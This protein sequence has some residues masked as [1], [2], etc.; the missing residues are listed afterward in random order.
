MT[1][2]KRRSHFLRWRTVVW[3][4]VLAS[5]VVAAPSQAQDV[6]LPEEI[7]GFAPGE[8]YRL[9]DYEQ[10][11][12][13]YEAVAQASNRVE[14]E[15]IG[16]THQ[17][18]DLLL[19]HIS[20]PEN[21]QNLEHYR[22]I[23]QRLALARD[24]DD[25]AARDLASEGK[26]VIWI[27]HGLH[28]AERAHSQAGPHL[29]YHLATDESPETARILD[30]VIL[31]MMPL[32]N[33][34]GHTVVVDWYREQRGTPFEETDAP[35]VWHEYIDHDNNRDWY[36]LLQ[37]ESRAVAEV[38]YNTWHPQIVLNHH[39]MG[40]SP[41]RMFIPPFDEPVNPHIPA[42]AVRGTNLVG[43]HMA[44]RFVAEGKAGIQQRSGFDMWWNGGMR[45]AP[46]FH[47]M[48]GILTESTHRS[49]VPRYWE[50]DEI[51]GT[52]IIGGQEQP[53]DEPSVFYPD[54]WM[55]GWSTLMQMV[56]YHHTASMA[57]LDI[58]SLRREAWL[59]NKY[60]MGRDA[61]A[62]GEEGSPFA[63]VVP[64]D[65]WDGPEALEMLRV[66]D[67]GGI[68]IHRATADFTADGAAYEAGSFVLYAGQAYRAHLRDLMEPQNYPERTQ[69]PGGP[70]DPPYDMAGWTLPIQMGVR[71]DIIE[72][73][74]AVGVERLEEVPT[75]PGRVVDAGS[76]HYLLNPRSNFA[77]RA[78]NRLLSEGH[79][80]LRTGESFTR[81]GVS[82][83]EGTFVI[84]SHGE[85]TTGLL[86]ELSSQLGL[87][88]HGVDAQPGVES[89]RLSQPRV[90]KYRS[91]V[92]SIDGGWT[93]WVFDQYGFDYD[94][95][96]DGD[97]R[98]G[99]LAGYDVLIMPAAP[100]RNLLRGHEEGT[101]PEAYVGGLGTEGA[102]RIKE[103]VQAGGTVVAWDG[104]TDFL[105][106]QL[107]L[108]VRN[109]VATAGRDTFFIPGSLL[110]LE[111]GTDHPVAYG[112]QETTGAWFV[113]RRGSQSRS[114]EIVRPA[115]VDD[116]YAGERRR[117]DPPRVE[118][119]ARFAED[120]LLASGWAR[121]E[122]RF[123][124]GQPAVLRVG[125]G[126]GDLV[127]IGVRPQ[128]RGQP[129]GTFK[130]V[131]NSIYASAMEGL[132]RVD[133]AET[134]EE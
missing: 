44:N 1:V 92:K 90:A 64:V 87:D 82:F 134:P 89:Y 34:D 56:E 22:S 51:T 58:A 17:G 93:R 8:N 120:D 41:V 28:S 95:L 21:L 52:Q 132:V 65:Q 26:A 18:R 86:R 43:E 14:L 20:S 55:G 36:M 81:N 77:A 84:A 91:W 62:A 24:L 69:Y 118:V 30:D 42:M 9:A 121:G 33:P 54:P 46:Y 10:L 110:N 99:A 80:M 37:N 3:L 78:V 83:E 111:V 49:P 129:R 19:L 130:L 112:M 50:R 60:Q 96:Y 122:D 94:E 68:E 109:R 16:Q 4:S 128:F 15:V 40:E 127:L 48:V 67:R 12:T 76:S 79:E 105:I 61:I 63:Y 72:A 5:L 113:E 100:A 35:W 75:L 131:F 7:I 106:E 108:P 13:Y 66:L 88:F 32:M 73:P 103:F 123:L 53:Y 124:A 25:E 31:L 29:A 70:P 45:T 101:M 107:G 71:A 116:S 38:I 27:D 102:L 74:F 117:A 98:G 125:L 114:F 115:E 39:Q 23:S 59:Y 47:N 104:S 119:V 2:P 57:A 97:I 11:K 126:E 6:P 85:T 133:S